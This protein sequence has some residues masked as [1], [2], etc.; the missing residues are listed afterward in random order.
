MKFFFTGVVFFLFVI[1]SACSQPDSRYKSIEHLEHPPEFVDLLED[2]TTASSVKPVATSQAIKEG[3]GNKVG[4]EHADIGS[5]IIVKEPYAKTWFIVGLVLNQQEIE[6]TDRNRDEGYYYVSF[7]PDEIEASN[8]GVLSYFFGEDI[9]AQRTYS[10]QLRESYS[11]TEITASVVQEAE[12]KP[13]SDSADE[14]R[15]D[16]KTDGAEKLLEYLY[17]YLKEGN[18]DKEKKQDIE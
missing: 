3:L 2:K 15:E 6:I 5:T 7:D 4:F 1:L 17:K 11:E 14:N 13:D 9:Y 12:D 10:L 18:L 8:K 16:E